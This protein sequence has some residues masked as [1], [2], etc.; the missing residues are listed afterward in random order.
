MAIKKYALN[1]IRLLGASPINF[2]QLTQRTINPK[3][4]VI[5]N[6][7]SGSV[8]PSFAAVAGVDPEVSWDMT[9]IAIAFGA[10]SPIVG[11]GVGS[12]LTYTSLEAYYEGKADLGARVGSS[13]S[14]KATSAKAFI[15][16][17][18]LTVDQGG[19]AKLSCFMLLLSA[20]GTTA[21]LAYTDAVSVPSAYATQKYTLGTVKLN[22]STL[23]SIMGFTLDFGIEITASGQS[24]HTYP[25]FATVSKRTPKLT[26]RTSDVTAASTFPATGTAFSAAAVVYLRKFTTSGITYSNASTEHIS[27]TIPNSQGIILPA[28]TSASGADDASHEIEVVPLEGSSAMIAVATGVAIS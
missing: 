17:R 14:L 28:S 13:L 6:S 5:Y 27:F 20:D 25:S 1:H 10:I 8:S 23:D 19:E 16:P 21:P 22:G 2:T 11:L 26:V 4:N 18:S 9:D 15:V 24:G 7:G 3:P 12:G